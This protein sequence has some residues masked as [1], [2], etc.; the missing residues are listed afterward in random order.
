MTN[1]ITFYGTYCAD[2]K[3]QIAWDIDVVFGCE[4]PILG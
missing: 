4:I 3:A 2:I 1:T